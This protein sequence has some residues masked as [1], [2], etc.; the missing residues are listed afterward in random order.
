MN[1]VGITSNA[2][3]DELES[4][5]NALAG[6]HLFRQ[7]AWLRNWWRHQ[8]GLEL[9]TMAIREE[10][11]AV[12]G[13]VPLAMERHLVKGRVLSLLGSGK[14]CSDYMG[15]LSRPADEMRVATAAGK[16]LRTAAEGEQ[17]R[18]WKWD[19][20][21][22]EGVPKSDVAVE[23]MAE[24]V[25]GAE[26]VEQ[27]TSVRCWPISLPNDWET[28]LMGLSKR[29]RRKL[30]ELERKYLKTGRAQLEVAQTPAQVRE[31]LQWL[32]NL[33]TQRRATMPGGGCFDHPWFQPFLHD[34]AQE[35]L[36]SDQLMLNRL[37]LDG[38]VAACSIGFRSGDTIL[39]YQC[40]F[41]P[42]L[43]EHTPGW[44]L[45]L[46]CVKRAIEAGMA[47]FDFLRGDEPY[48][49]RLGGEPVELQRIRVTAE[50]AVARIRHQVWN[51]GGIAKRSLTFPSHTGAS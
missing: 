50:S 37:V 24:T 2:Q 20:L 18:T 23:R 16:W 17:G 25:G 43:V 45:N 10:S 36:A 12:V 6:E 40:G 30:R 13:I 15:I 33:H 41:D 28:Y 48:K 22:L 35:F 7:W 21:D 46:C 31:Y 51:L 1:I 8:Q 27:T 49:R 39:L 19:L 4:G 44:T 38:Q 9:R 3:L 32:V 47:R 42:A 5:W 34:V 11:G 26:R 29:C 14:A